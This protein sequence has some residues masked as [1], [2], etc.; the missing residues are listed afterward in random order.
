MYKYCQ[1]MNDKMTNTIGSGTVSYYENRVS[2]RQNDNILS[3]CLSMLVNDQ[4]TGT[5]PYL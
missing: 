2:F 3:Y 5:L 4:M 1:L